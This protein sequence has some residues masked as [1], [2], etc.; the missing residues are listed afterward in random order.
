MDYSTEGHTRKR[1]GRPKKAN[2]KRQTRSNKT[3][4]EEE[5]DSSY[6]PSDSGRL[7]EGDEEMDDNW[8][9]GA[10]A[11]GILAAAGLGVGTAGVFGAEV[12]AR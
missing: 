8:E 12:V 6:T 4:A 5:T 2:A 10:W 11:W 3:A 1:L 7:D 9:V